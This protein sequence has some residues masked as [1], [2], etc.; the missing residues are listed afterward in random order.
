[1]V[2]VAGSFGATVIV[3]IPMLLILR[4]LILR[5]EATPIVRAEVMCATFIIAIAAFVLHYIGQKKSDD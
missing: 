1:M 5:G 2:A 4:G 3:T